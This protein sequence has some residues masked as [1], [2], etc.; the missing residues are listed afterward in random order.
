LSKDEV[1]QVSFFK[2]EMQLN[3][4]FPP[5]RPASALIIAI[6]VRADEV[7]Y[8]MRQMAA[9]AEEEKSRKRVGDAVKI[10]RPD[11]HALRPSLIEKGK[12]RLGPGKFLG[13][14]VDLQPV[15]AGDEF[16]SQRP[17][18]VNQ[19]FLP[20]RVKRAEVPWA[21]KM[22]GLGRHEENRKEGN[23]GGRVDRG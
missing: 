10:R 18:G 21:G 16:D 19:I 12:E 20:A 1:R 22:E 2:V 5:E 13:R 23:E 6:L 11:G 4:L 17:F 7:M 15:L 9:A 14:R 3:H 8:F